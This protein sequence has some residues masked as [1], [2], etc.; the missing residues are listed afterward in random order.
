[1]GMLHGV[2]FGFD[3][4][5]T[6]YAT[7]GVDDP[8]VGEHRGRQADTKLEFR[9]Q[10]RIDDMERF[11]EDARHM[12]TLAGEVEFA[13]LG[14]TF[15]I[16]DGV[17]HLFD[18]DPETGVLRMVYAFGFTGGDGRRYF[19]KGQKDLAA[20]DGS[21]LKH[22]ITHLYTR[23]H[24]G[25]DETGPVVAAGVV[26]FLLK[27]SVSLVRSMRVF[28]EATVRQRIAAYAAFASLASGSLRDEYLAGWRPL[29][30]ASYENLVLSGT[31]AAD[32]DER[33]FFLVAGEHQK[34]F[35][36]GDDQPF[37]DIL[38][39]LGDGG[40]GWRRFCLSAPAIEGL[41]VRLSGQRATFAG[42]LY[43][44]VDGFGTSV[45]AMAAGGEG[46]VPWDVRFDLALDVSPLPT[47]S[48]PFPFLPP[49]L[50][51]LNADLA[52]ALREVLPETHPLGIQITPHAVR[53]QS[54][55]LS[56][57]RPGEQRAWRVD[58]ARTAG[59]GERGTFRSVREP[60]LRYHYL[61][62]GRAPEPG[63]RVQIR[64]GVLRDEREQWAKDRLDRY[65]GALID[66]AASAEYDVHESS[67]KVR[68]LERPD[69]DG[70]LPFAV[71]GDPLLEVANDH[72]STGVFF[73]RLRHVR[74][75]D[76]V[77]RVALE[78]DM[79]LLRREPIGTDREATV[80]VATGDVAI[81]ALDVALDRSGFD[82]A[83]DRALAAS[84]K[85]RDAFAIVIK[86]NFM[87]SYSR[88]DTSTYTDP[89]LVAR[90][91]ERLKNRGFTNI[92]VVEAQST[93]GQFFENRGVVQ[94]AQHL[95]YDR[96][97]CPIVDM[98]EESAGR[99]VDFPPPLGPHPVSPTW[100]GADFRVSFAKNKTH[101]Y[102]YYTL[103][104]KNIYGTLCLP[105]KFKEY[106]CERGIYEPTIQ[107]LKAY[108]VHFGIVDAWASADGPFGVFACPAPKETRRVIAGED[109]VA[110]D[111]VGAS[112][113]GLDPR[114]SPYMRL[115]V[116]AFGK[117]RIRLDG[118][119]KP[120]RPWVNVP[121]ALALF[122]HE[123]LDA[124]F[125]FG[126]AFY[127]ACA[128]MD[129]VAFPDKPGNGWKRCA[130]KLTVPLRRTFFVRAGENPTLANRVA[131]RLLY[132]A[133]F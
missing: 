74:D 30:D 11:L 103:T 1:M 126:N 69:A 15:P 42:R 98:T 116:D 104:L 93:Y 112:M 2:R 94:V 55:D 50:R 32:G 13:P 4:T 83:V 45:T 80:A 72:L 27:D 59:E 130:R 101:C 35:P 105:N 47:V 14:G 29:Y 60:T 17:I 21:G 70:A 124:R 66:F 57:A 96:V 19:L 58:P 23:I 95:G 113:M 132:W 67:C 62:A 33:P 91:V 20:G 76:G 24:Q 16:R 109:L 107:Y 118:E 31:L 6:G 88:L 63:A 41:D 87:F 37:S 85:T 125:D 127:M 52:Q 10:A 43:E 106:H 89:I 129:P 61:A 54:G 68:P 38:L 46:M 99:N 7:L 65:L 82:A 128:N 28:G 86:P 110:V 111:W 73:R 75:A 34:G 90:L 114:I 25:D 115:A 8:V 26:C 133:G 39:L 12:G 3:E 5:M 108:P 9:V 122:A 123:G 48:F 53:V 18:L 64:T 22:D 51:H 117:P 36:W 119:A 102:A 100:A 44:I 81:G 79:D 120:Y 131:S 56:L 97:G 78:E 92:K 71:E 77:L 40:T 121:P 84:G 49:M